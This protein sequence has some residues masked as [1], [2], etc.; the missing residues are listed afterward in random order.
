MCAPEM[1]MQLQWLYIV[2]FLFLVI[3]PHNLIMLTN[4]KSVKEC[5]TIRQLNS[6][7]Q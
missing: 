2:Q 4:V 5:N 1:T 3:L 6:H 7:Q